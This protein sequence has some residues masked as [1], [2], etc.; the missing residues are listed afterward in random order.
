MPG[1]PASREGANSQRDKCSDTDYADSF[2]VLGSAF[3]SVHE[4]S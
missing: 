1:L 2:G 4:P 3:Q